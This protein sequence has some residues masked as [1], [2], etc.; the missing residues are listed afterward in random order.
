MNICCR[1]FLD[2]QYFF[3]RLSDKER[4]VF[5][6]PIPQ[7]NI[8]ALG[9]MLKA[10]ANRNNIDLRLYFNLFAVLSTSKK[11]FQRRAIGKGL[12]ISIGNMPALHM[13]IIFSPM[14]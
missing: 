4:F 1:R 3:P 5:G 11:N 10:W 13:C 14:N 12:F 8:F 9:K 2:H 7:N 6:K